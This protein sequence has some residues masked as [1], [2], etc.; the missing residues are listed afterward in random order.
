M[1]H[2]V[3]RKFITIVLTLTTLSMSAQQ[4]VPSPASQPHAGSNWQHVQALPVGAS[5]QVKASK[6]HASCKLKSVDADSLTCTSNKDLVFQRNDIVTIKVPRRGRSALIGTAI[7]AGGG[8]VFGFAASG[9]K[10]GTG[11]IIPRPLGALIFAV[12][13][14]VIGAVTGA[15]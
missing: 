3:T 10:A 6:S 1:E 2:S 4:I 9:C 8:A 7:G 13:G 12:P 14:A 11:C 5:I 15:L